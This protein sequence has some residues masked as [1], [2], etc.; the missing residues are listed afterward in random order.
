LAV[1]IIEITLFRVLHGIAQLVLV[2]V[3][4][5]LHRVELWAEGDEFRQVQ[6]AA[7]EQGLEPAN[8]EPGFFGNMD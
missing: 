5:F 7:R 8:Q 6:H 3:E 2:K 4:N 1:S